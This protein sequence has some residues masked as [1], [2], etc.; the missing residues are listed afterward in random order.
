ML[1]RTQ[2]MKK[3]VIELWDSNA[4]FEDPVGSDPARELRLLVIFGILLMQRE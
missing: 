3:F 1:K 2:K 4:V